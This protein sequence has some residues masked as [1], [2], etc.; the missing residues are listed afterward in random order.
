MLDRK[1]SL[2]ADSMNLAVLLVDHE[3]G[4][5]VGGNVSH[6]ARCNVCESDTL[7]LY[8]RHDWHAD[9]VHL[10]WAYLETD[11]IVFLASHDMGDGTR[12]RRPST[13]LPPDEFRTLEDTI[14]LPDGAQW[15]FDCPWSLPGDC[16]TQAEEAW[17]AVADLD[18]AAEFAERGM[19]VGH[20][21]IPRNVDWKSPRWTWVF[22]L[23]CGQDADT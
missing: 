12:I 4:I 22:F 19:K 16:L 10:I 3:T 14:A 2:H 7:P 8:Q 1:W 5:L 9:S 23:C 11:E 20:L 15:M 6:Y 17:E 13:F 21:M 18:I